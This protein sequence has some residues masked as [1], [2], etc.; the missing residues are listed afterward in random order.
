MPQNPQQTEFD[1]NDPKKRGTAKTEKTL[2]S[3]IIVCELN[4]HESV[5]KL[6][7]PTGP[8]V[9]SKLAPQRRAT[10]LRE[11]LAERSDCSHE[12]QVCFCPPAAALIVHPLLHKHVVNCHYL[13]STNPDFNKF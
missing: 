9:V 3:K 13:V 6:S 1:R 5:R 2:G 11:R 7:K 8:E 4:R 10:G 12:C